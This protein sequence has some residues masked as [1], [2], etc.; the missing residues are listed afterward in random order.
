MAKNSNF[1]IGIAG[2]ANHGKTTLAET[3]A[4]KRTKTKEPEKQTGRTGRTK[5]IQWNPDP[6]KTI[7]LLDVPGAPK[8][9]KNTIRGLCRVDLAIL[10][11]AADEG[12]MPQ[13]RQHLKILEFF[14]A[15]GGG[16]VI[17]KTDTVDAETCS[18]AEL[19][20]AETVD[21]FG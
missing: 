5:I 18:L 2:H 9:L 8:Y 12:V 15:K 16:I 4:G 14:G 6:G 20:A 11:I 13:T 17:S 21:P 1:I 7:A 10:V 19:E 3:I